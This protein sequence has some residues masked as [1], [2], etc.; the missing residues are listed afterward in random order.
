MVVKGRVLPRKV[1]HD[2]HS[3]I[4]EVGWHYSTHSCWIIITPMIRRQNPYI[5]MPNRLPPERMDP[6]KLRFNL[7]SDHS[8]P[9]PSSWFLCLLQ[10]KDHVVVPNILMPRLVY[11]RRRILEKWWLYCYNVVTQGPGWHLLTDVQFNCLVIFEKGK[12]SYIIYKMDRNLFFYICPVVDPYVPMEKEF[13]L[14]KK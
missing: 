14:Q 2:F 11:S 3:Y 1:R 13:L 4:S 12:I 6:L 7:N 10:V 5:T 8:T 9:F